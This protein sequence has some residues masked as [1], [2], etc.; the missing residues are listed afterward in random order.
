M[1][2]FKKRLIKN[3]IIIPI[4]ISVAAAALFFAVLYL[5]SDV[6]P[7]TD[8]TVSISDY[9][10]AEIVEAK[11]LELVGST[12]SRKDIPQIAPNTVIGSIKSGDSSLPLIY[13]SNDV[14]AI[15]KINLSNDSKLFGEI[16]TVLASC[17]KSDADFLKSMSV[18][19]ILNVNTHYGSFAY[20]VTE[21][22][23]VNDL[24]L[25]KK[26]GDGIGRALVLYTDNN[27]KA[28]MSDEYFTVTCKMTS[29]T[30]ITE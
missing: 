13:N 23:A 20:E 2:H 10:K 19:D 17:Y 26:Q 6:F 30:K 11:P 14:N 16:G 27:D 22:D 9:E 21:T 3:G 12:V 25:V 1:D 4:I 18:G 8:N 29:G 24:L 15:G 5:Y 7:F 28:G